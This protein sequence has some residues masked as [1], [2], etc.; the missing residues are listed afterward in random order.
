MV[1]VT[2]GNASTF[3]GKRRPSDSAAGAFKLSVVGAVPAATVNFLVRLAL[4]KLRKVGRGLLVEHQNVLR[5]FQRSAAGIE[6][7]RA[8]AFVPYPFITEHGEVGRAQHLVIGALCEKQHRALRLDGPF[9]RLPQLRERQRHIP[10]VPG[11]AVG[12]IGQQ[13][14]HAMLRQGTQSLNA[15]REVQALRDRPLATV[16]RSGGISDKIT[17]PFSMGAEDAFGDRPGFH[18]HEAQQAPYSRYSSPNRPDGIAACC[19]ALNEHRVNCNTYKDQHALESP[20]QTGS[21]HDSS[22]PV[23]AKLPV[24]KRSNGDGGQTGQQIDFQHPA[25][26]QNEN[27]NPHRLHRKSNERTTA[28][29]SPKSGPKSIASSEVSSS[30]SISAETSVEP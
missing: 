5:L 4:F 11:R 13:H 12:R 15:V 28:A 24:G 30:A 3:P 8:A 2:V 26:H 1:V 22:G 27:D 23:A 29:N 17:F 20:R 16:T 9:H 18:Q 21:L 25:I 19:D 14:I 6:K 7:T 10:K